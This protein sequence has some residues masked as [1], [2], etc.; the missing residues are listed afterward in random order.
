MKQ[1]KNT[2]VHRRMS[3]TAWNLR[4]N[5]QKIH[6]RLEIYR[7]ASVFSLVLSMHCTVAFRIA[8][9]YALD[10]TLNHD[11]INIPLNTR[12]RVSEHVKCERIFFCVF[13]RKSFRILVN[14]IYSLMVAC[15]TWSL[16]ICF[17]ILQIISSGALTVF[18]LSKNNPHNSMRLTL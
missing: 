15:V 3:A 16:A 6:C 11:A 1:P 2:L 8:A 7:I 5:K 17:R 18:S 13:R 14:I 9:I 4:W 10:I 12:C